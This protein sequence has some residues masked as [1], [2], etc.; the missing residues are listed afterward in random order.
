MFSKK[1]ITFFLLLAFISS[2]FYLPVFTPKAQAQWA[3]IDVK[4][5]ARE[6]IDNF[7]QVAAQVLVEEI[8]RST[9]E[10]AN[11]GFDG[12]P[13]YATD[14]SQFLTN[15]ADNVAGEFIGG[16]DSPLR[17]LCSP[18]RVQIRLALIE[19]Y[20]P[21]VRYQCTLTE[22]ID[23]LG[24]FLD[25]GGWDDWFLITQNPSNNPY[26]AFLEAKIDLDSRVARA[27]G[28]E[29]EQLKW[30]SGFLSWSDCIKEDPSTGECLKR[31]PVKTPGTTIK[32]G[33]DNVLP[34]SL[35]KLITVNHIDQLISALGAGLLKKFV[36]SDEGLFSG[37]AAPRSSYFDS[38]RSQNSL[39]SPT[40][41]DPCLTGGVDCT[42]PTPP[43][44]IQAQIDAC[45]INCYT[46][47][48]CPPSPSL[49][50]Q[51]D[52]VNNCI[53]TTCY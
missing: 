12:N 52:I 26:G 37:N 1:V 18:F 9:V 33:L 48:N 34:S 51:L 2:T 30:N 32:A 5:F 40:G 8:V 38:V 45:I 41:P 22:V 28:I 50:P 31:G 44:A 49:C 20:I 47:N 24:N 6:I 36:F 10:W 11:S 27:V 3:V 35:S 7:A 42:N 16:P 46:I 39:P 14:L 21:P 29:S 13:A 4:A 43:P 25:Q 53:A 23:N 15:T 17:F 19:S